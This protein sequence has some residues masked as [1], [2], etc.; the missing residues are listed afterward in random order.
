VA[1]QQGVIGEFRD[2]SRFSFG[3]TCKWFRHEFSPSLGVV[4]LSFSN[5]DYENDTFITQYSE[6]NGESKL[7][8]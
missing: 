7:A 8:H 2:F 3:F 1:C 6:E 5:I 4:L